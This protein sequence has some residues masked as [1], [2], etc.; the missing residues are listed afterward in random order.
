M[1]ETAEQAND[2]RFA[3]VGCGA[4]CRG[5]FVPLTLAEA[6]LWL[7]RGHSVAVLLEA[8]DETAWPP[9]AAEFGYNRLRS[10]PV[11]CGSGFVDVIAI[12][13][14]NVIPQCPNL[15][16]DNR[17]GIY[18]ERPLVCRIY[19]AEIN[20]FISL[21]PSAK[22]CPPESWGQGE[23]LGSDR[24]L[25]QQILQ[26]RQADRDDAQ[27][28][29]ELCE[30]LGMTVAAWKGDGFAIYLP[31]IGDML[32]AFERLGTGAR[33]QRPWHIA[34]R[35]AELVGDLQARA[36]AVEAGTSADYVFHELH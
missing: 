1:T 16:A 32:A 28:K 26:S 13:A 14:A 15:G 35:K 20:P 10:A 23:L 27:L 2:A 34:A 19:P 8:F 3:C 31:A 5:R 36:F 6:G 33:A 4:C 18:H 29:V 7:R 25:T 22:D 17:C 21:A 12:L 24:E 11:Q 30:T 9:E